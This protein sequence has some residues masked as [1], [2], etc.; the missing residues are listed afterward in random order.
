MRAKNLTSS[1]SDYEFVSG[2]A[3]RT[4]DYLKP[5]ILALLAE[6]GTKKVLDLG[7]GNGVLCQDMAKAGCTVSGCDPSKSAVKYA[8]QALPQALLQS[9]ERLR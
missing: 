5:P 1:A 3:P 7:C 9:A 4:N 2:N 6:I 8:Q